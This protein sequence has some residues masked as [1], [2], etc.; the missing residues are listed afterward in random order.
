[1]LHAS[2]TDTAAGV[3]AKVLK[4]KEVRRPGRPAEQPGLGRATVVLVLGP[5]FKGL[6][7]KVA[8]PQAPA[9]AKPTR[10]TRDLP[11]WDPRPC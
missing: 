10:A 1:M 8:A 6:A 9:A 7:G 2:G 5:D 11:A 4:V 3:V